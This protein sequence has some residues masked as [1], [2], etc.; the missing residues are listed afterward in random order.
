MYKTQP[1]LE[2][3]S[4]SDK[5]DGIIFDAAIG[6]Y[7]Y[8]Y[9]EDFNFYTGVECVGVDRVNGFDV[10]ETASGKR[11]AIYSYANHQHMGITVDDFERA[12]NCSE[13]NKEYY[14]KKR[15]IAFAKK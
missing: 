2:N 14:A 12:I 3:F 7:S 8:F 15:A 13:T 5:I 9:T 1:H 4:E 6:Q 10:V 11:Y